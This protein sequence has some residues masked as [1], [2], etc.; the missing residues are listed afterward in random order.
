M[1]VMF[2]FATFVLGGNLCCSFFVVADAAAVDSDCDDSSAGYALR[3]H[4]LILSNQ[5]LRFSFGM[6]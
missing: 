6:I 2:A 1:R 5:F 4:L 3:I